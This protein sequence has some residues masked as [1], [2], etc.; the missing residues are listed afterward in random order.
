MWQQT[1]RHECTMSGIGIHTGATVSMTLLPAP[2][3]HGI[4]F[5]RTDLPPSVSRIPVQYD[6]VTGTQL[7]TTITNDHRSSVSTIEHLMAALWAC[8][9]HNVLIRLDGPEVPVMDGSSREFIVAIEKTGACKQGKQQ[10]IIEVLAPIS[11]SH[12]GA[13]LSIVPSDRLTVDMTIEFDH[14]MVGTQQLFFEADSKDFKSN[15][16]FARTFGFMKDIEYLRANGLAK[17]GSLENA[18]VFSDDA[19]MNAE[20]L[21]AK[22]EC[23]RHKILDCL[24]DLY[25]GG[26]LQGAVTG[27]CSGHTVN[28]LLLR[29][30]FDKPNAWRLTTE[31]E[32]LETCQQVAM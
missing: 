17:G 29:A 15:I 27:R 28:N 11:V 32:L 8:D 3:D 13:S 19:V 31:D 21:R 20:G 24:G 30:L 26:I 6:R 12:E 16:A 14:K 18:V 10:P 23:V 5:E 9:I 7:G 22:D 25:V 1:L 4:V 2:V